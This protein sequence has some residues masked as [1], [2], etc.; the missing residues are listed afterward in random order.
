[1]KGDDISA[2]DI[3]VAARAKITDEKNWGK[4]SRRSRLNVTTC[5]AAEA[6]EE[7]FR[8]PGLY[9]PTGYYDER[10]LAFKALYHAAGLDWPSDKLPDWNDAPER[11]HK[12]VLAAFDLAIATLRLGEDR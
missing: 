9:A 1:M 2:L 8:F 11:T 4:L 5:C 3:L 12:E 7:A 6:V 10:R